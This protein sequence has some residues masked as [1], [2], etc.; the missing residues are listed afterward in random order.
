MIIFIRKI[1]ESA[2]RSDLFEFVSKALD[3]KLKF[4]IGQ[5]TEI[6][7]LILQDI[8]TKE[9]EYHGLV[10]IDSQREALKAIKKLN[11]GWFLDR[12]VIVREYKHR[13]WR[14]EYWNVDIEI[15]GLKDRKTNKDRRR[16]MIRV[17]D[18]SFLHRPQYGNSELE[19]KLLQPLALRLRQFMS[20][21]HN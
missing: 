2:T 15:I 6:E 19:Q 4:L 8:R 20:T 14:D 18:P 3:R 13:S 1:S 21:P 11:G 17:Y 10:H 16:R 7:I 9:I 12:S 5:I